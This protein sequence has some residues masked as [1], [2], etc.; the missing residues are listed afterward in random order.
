[1]EAMKAD[2]LG[3]PDQRE[4]TKQLLSQ[5][6]VKCTEQIK[7]VYTAPVFWKASCLVW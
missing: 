3:E 6:C 7:F 2:A 4:A 5:Q 1:M